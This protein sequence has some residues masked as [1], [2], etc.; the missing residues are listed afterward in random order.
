MPQTYKILGQVNPNA[1][2]NTDL[3]VVP[4]GSQAVVSTISVCSTAQTDTYRIAVVPSG[5]SVS[6]ENYIVYDGV[7][8]FKDSIILTTGL[9]LSE[10]D[11]VVVYSAGSGLAFNAYGVEIT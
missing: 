8:N 9:S 5:D 6:L 10:S 1:T 2:T 7:V 3:Y 11:K 4:S